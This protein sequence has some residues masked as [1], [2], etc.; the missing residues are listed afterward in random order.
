MKATRS[1]HKWAHVA[2]A[3][4]IPEVSIGSVEKM[5]PI[6]KI[7]AIPVSTETISLME[8]I[9]LLCDVPL[10]VYL[11]SQFSQAAGRYYV[12]YAKKKSEL[13]FN[14]PLKRARRRIM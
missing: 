13:V 14:A 3:I 2:C 7:S 6:T 11:I 4:W 5:E 8:T 10:L 12:Y 1:G 9:L